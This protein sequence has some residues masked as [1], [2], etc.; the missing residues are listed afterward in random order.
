MENKEKIIKSLELIKQS[1][2]VYAKNLLKFLEVFV[3]G[4]VGLIPMVVLM[5]L[6]YAYIGTGL[7]EKAPL[8]LNI[9]LAIVGIILLFIS[10]YYAIV[11]SLKAKVASILLLKNNFT[12]PRDNFKAAKPYIA[13]FLGVSVLTIVLTIAWGILFIIPALI[14][15]IYYGFATYIL[16]V[17]D[18]R[19]FSSVE[20]SYDLVKGYW[21]P[22]FGRLALVSFIGFLLYAIISAPMSK[23]TQGEAPYI[24]YNVVTNIIWAGLS[25][26]FM[27]Y[28]YKLYQSLKQVNK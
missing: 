14:F 12:S 25:P 21:W 7:A 5:I 6:A 16:V 11:Y 13:R 15:G 28:F 23:M 10:F 20:S 17:E 4:L 27:V 8:A 26:Y 3:Y 9:V 2:Q 22:V 1:W 24:I 19:P 18:K